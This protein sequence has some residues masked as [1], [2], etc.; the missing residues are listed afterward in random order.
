MG[1]ATGFFVGGLGMLF[2]KLSTEE[3]VPEWRH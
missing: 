1:D 2:Y 3:V